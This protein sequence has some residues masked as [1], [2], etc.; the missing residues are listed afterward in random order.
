MPVLFLTA[1]A[2][3]VGLLLILSW[4]QAVILSI[5]VHRR[6]DQLVL[7][8]DLGLELLVLVGMERLALGWRLTRVEHDVEATN[9]ARRI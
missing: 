1:D 9:H 5:K 8:D 3:R 4:L 2:G 7:L 6:S